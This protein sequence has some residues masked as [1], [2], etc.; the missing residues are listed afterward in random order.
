LLWAEV[1]EGLNVFLVIAGLLGLGHLLT[2]AVGYGFL[3]SGP[4]ERGGLGL[5][6]ATASVAAFHLILTILLA[7]TQ[8]QTVWGDQYFSV[9]WSSFVTE[10]NELG[11][12]IYTLCAA[13]RGW[14]PG[15]RA[16]LAVFANLAEV[17]LVVLFLLTLRAAARSA[18]D[19]RRA[20]TAMQAVIANSVAAGALVLV[21][22]LFGLLFM[23]VR[24]EKGGMVA[25]DSL[26]HL[27]VYLTQIAVAL[28][29]TLV[30]KAV[31]DGIDYRP[32]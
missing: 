1:R 13:P 25:V 32:D 2:S 16:V 6:I 4:R 18:R 11:D 17:A 28:W 3:V 9:R 7:T 12:L 29:T 23:A 26:Y 24:T 5:A 31:K 27:V 20:R 14:S 8:T 22:V 30:I 21:A 10:G 15:G 19:P